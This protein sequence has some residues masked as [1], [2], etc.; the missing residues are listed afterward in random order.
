M[1]TVLTG[2]RAENWSRRCTVLVEAS[3]GKYDSAMSHFDRIIGVAA[4][5]MMY[6]LNYYFY[7][8]IGIAV[9]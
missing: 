6:L 9:G 1:K 5:L 2:F 7:G 3:E 4:P 8:L